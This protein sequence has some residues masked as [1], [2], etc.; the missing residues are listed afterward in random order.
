MVEYVSQMLCV[1]VK[2]EYGPDKEGKKRRIFRFMLMP[3]REDYF[4]LL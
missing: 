3:V 4:P 2:K 1:G